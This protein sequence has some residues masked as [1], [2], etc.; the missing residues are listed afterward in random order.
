MLLVSAVIL[1]TQQTAMY[2]QFAIN[3]GT[4][5]PTPERQK[6]EIKLLHTEAAILLLYYTSLWI[7]KLSFLVFFRRLGQKIIGQK[8]WWWCVLVFT[9]GT[10][11]SCIG[12]MSFKCL[13]SSLDYFHGKYAYS[14]SEALIL[15]IEAEC[16]HPSARDHERTTEIHNCVV[17]VVSD[18]ASKFS[19]I[20]VLYLDSNARSH[21]DSGTDV[22]ECS[23][24]VGEKADPHGHLLPHDHCHHCLRSAYH[25]D[26]LKTQNGRHELAVFVEWH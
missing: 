22:M 18:L 1:Q 14:I 25:F 19:V 16:T 11:A 21:H 15:T 6:A 12:S 4:I 17:D 7:V 8:I 5:I 20:G 2:R 10:W 23:Y 26:H 9:V 24:L 13:L 3:A